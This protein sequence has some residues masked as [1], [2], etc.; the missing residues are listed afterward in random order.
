MRWCFEPIYGLG[1][2]NTASLIY[3]AP[4]AFWT[5][6]FADRVPDAGGGPAAKSAVWGFEPVFFKPE[7]VKT[8]LDLILFDEWQLPRE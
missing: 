7:Q 8:A 6:T 2:L 5:L 1:C 4:V 3:R